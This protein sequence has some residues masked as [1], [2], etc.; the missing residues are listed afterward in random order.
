MYDKGWQVGKWK[1][2]ESARTE[3]A[4]SP[5]DGHEGESGNWSVPEQWWNQGPGQQQQPGWMQGPEALSNINWTE[6]GHQLSGDNWEGDR[7]LVGWKPQEQ[8]VQNVRDYSNWTS[9]ACAKGSPGM[10]QEM[11]LNPFQ[12]WMGVEVVQQNPGNASNDGLQAIADLLKKNMENQQQLIY[13][14]QGKAQDT[15]QSEQ[16]DWYTDLQGNKNKGNQTRPVLNAGKNLGKKIS[17]KPLINTGKDGE[18]AVGKTKGT[19]QQWRN[20]GQQYQPMAAME[21]DDKQYQQLNQ[22]PDDGWGKKQGKK[23]KTEAERHFWKGMGKRSEKWNKT[24][25]SEQ[26]GTLWDEP[27][28]IGDKKNT[29]GKDRM[30]H[31]TIHSPEYGEERTTMAPGFRQKNQESWQQKAMEDSKEYRWYPDKLGVKEADIQQE[32]QKKDMWTAE[33][34]METDKWGPKVTTRQKWEHKNR[35]KKWNDRKEHNLRRTRTIE[36]SDSRSDSR[37]SVYKNPR[38][39]HQ[40]QRWKG[41]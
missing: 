12:G 17:N 8:Y 5:M 22:L 28:P 7:E 39:F 19:Q 31:S 20:M 34:D 41:G 29:K 35:V 40:S 1:I 14:R 13:Q 15:I 27:E 2:M 16:Q 9:S 4:M 10:R 25:A 24:M 37:E 36:E 18:K 33:R 32:Q 3:D 38:P 6:Q 23:G 21:Q 26:D 30:K 11:N